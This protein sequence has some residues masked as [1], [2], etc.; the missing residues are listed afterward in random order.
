MIRLV[1]NA[2]DLGLHPRIDEGIF[3]A[4]AS[5]ILTSATLLVTGRTAIESVARA[6]ATGL[7]LG[8]HLA[9]TTRLPPAIRPDRVPRLAPSGRFRPSWVE[10]TR[11][12]TMGRIPP[13]EVEAELRAQVER[14]RALGAEPDHLDTHQHLHLLPGIDLIVQR[15]AKEEGLP[16]RWPAEHPRLEWLSRPGAAL[17]S[18][19][20]AALAFAAPRETRHRVQG[21]GM[22]EAGVLDEH[23]L[24][25]LLSQLPTGDFELGCHPGLEDI[26]VPEDPNWRY[27]WR[28]E[29]EALTSPRVR[30]LIERRSIRLTTYR[31]LHDV[32][33]SAL[34]S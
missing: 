4:H 32:K 13:D 11:D 27:G 15:I 31:Q 12:W 5:G 21:I 22:F 7:A 18:T 6:R 3:R 33:L 19:L 30:R 16:L 9:L 2:D 10:L 17:K 8:V 23:R 25:R 26:H 28:A 14:A 29:L 24:A 34:A 1:V 20:L